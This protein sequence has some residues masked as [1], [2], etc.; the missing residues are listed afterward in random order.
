MEFIKRRG[1]LRINDERTEKNLS[2]ARSTLLKESEFSLNECHVLYNCTHAHALRVPQFKHGTSNS[3]SSIVNRN[4][5]IDPRRFPSLNSTFLQRFP[6]HLL[7]TEEHRFLWRNE[8]RRKSF[9][10]MSRTGF[11]VACHFASRLPLPI[12]PRPRIMSLLLSQFFS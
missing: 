9:Y 8:N 5:S 4:F 11:V 6:R 12:C 2:I 1:R 7:I 10:I 3:T